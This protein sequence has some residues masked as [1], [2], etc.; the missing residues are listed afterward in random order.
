M[1]INSRITHLER[2][3]KINDGYCPCGTPSIDLNAADG[4]LVINGHCPQCLRPVRKSTFAEIAKAGE[5]E[6]DS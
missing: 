3:M 4:N 1:D 6:I 2:N 5:M